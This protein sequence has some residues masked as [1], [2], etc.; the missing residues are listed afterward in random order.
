MVEVNGERISD[1]DTVVGNIE[2]GQS[3][4]VDLS[5]KGISVGD[6]DIDV[7]VTYEDADGNSY[8]TAK[9]VSLSVIEPVEEVVSEDAP[10][11]NMTLVVAV[12]GAVILIIV[13]SGVAR[14][15]KEKKYA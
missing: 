3:S 8:E 12:V 14:K 9:T 2:M 5:V 4:N 7:K 10:A 1:A 13:I 6:E 15:K 11:V